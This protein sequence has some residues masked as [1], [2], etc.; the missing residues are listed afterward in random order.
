MIKIHCSN[1]SIQQVQHFNQSNLFQ[2]QYSSNSRPVYLPRRGGKKHNQKYF[3]ILYDL[4]YAL[5]LLVSRIYS[6]LSSIQDIPC[7]IQYLG[8]TLYYLVSKIYS[9]LSSIQ[10]IPCIIQYLG[11]T[12]YYLV[13]RIYPVLSSIQDLPCII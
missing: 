1:T 8:F 12:L 10:D 2:E 3:Y 9:V 6:V 4:E 7:I 13:S 11:Y 5:Y